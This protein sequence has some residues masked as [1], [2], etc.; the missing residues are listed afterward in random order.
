MHTGDLAPSDNGDKGKAWDN[1]EA[2]GLALPRTDSMDRLSTTSSGL[3]ATKS[4]A[5]T[6]SLKYV[7][8][9]MG[10]TVPKILQNLVLLC[11]ASHSGWI[12]ESANL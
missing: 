4:L 12:L 1:D 9:R 10:K 6:K 11:S 2:Q 8:F 7:R 5:Q 3:I